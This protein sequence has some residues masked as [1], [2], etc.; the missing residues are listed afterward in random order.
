[1]AAG[2]PREDR[3]AGEVPD[4]LWPKLMRARRVTVALLGRAIEAARL[5]LLA[6]FEAEVAKADVSEEMRAVLA[7]AFSELAA[8][9]IA[10][11]SP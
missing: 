3:P 6:S 8:E 4:D 9:R 11:L 5:E 1:M 7:T 2:E 10:L